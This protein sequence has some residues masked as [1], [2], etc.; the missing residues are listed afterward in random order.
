[1]ARYG[2]GRY[3]QIPALRDYI[4]RIGAEE[5]NFRTFIKRD[6]KGHY[7]TERVTIKI[8]SDGKVTCPDKNMLPSSDEAKE[9]EK[10]I[11]DYQ[12][13]WPKHQRVTRARAR[14]FMKTLAAD[15]V[16]Y[17]YITYDRS[18]EEVIMIQERRI[19]EDG[20][21]YIPWSFWAEDGKAGKWLRMEP[22]GK[23]P[24]WKPLIKD[25]RKDVDKIMVHEGAKAAAHITRL[26]TTKEGDSHPWIDELREYEHWGMQGG[27]L[28][29]QRTDYEELRKRVAEEVVYVCD[30]DFYGKEA[31]K[32]VSEH[33]GGHLKSI[34]FSRIFPKSWDMADP[35]PE[36]LFHRGKYVGKKLATY[37]EP[38]TWATDKHF[39]GEKGRPSVTIKSA[40]AEEWLHCAS[41]EVFFHVNY[42]DQLHVANTFNTII[43]P[44]S[45]VDD[46]A[47][48]LKRA[49]AT[50]G[51]VLKYD[52]SLK[53]G[54]YPGSNNKYFNTHI[55]SDV[56]SVKGD[57]GPWTT[58]MEYLLPD[59]HD[60]TEM[61]RWIA[62][63]VARPEIK[64]TYGVLLI[65]ETQGVGKSTLGEKILAPLVGI[66]NTSFPGEAD[67][68]DPNY[69]YWA[70]HHRLAVVHEIYAG[71]SSK[72]YNKMKSILTDK[73]IM[74]SKKYIDKYAIENWL[75]VF[76]CSNSTRALKLAIEDRRWFVP[77]V[78]EDKQPVRFWT[79]L[80]E[81]LKY[82]GLGIVKHWCEEWIKKNDI[83]LPG[84]DAPD[85]KKK[86]EVISEGYSDGMREVEEVLDRIKHALD[87]KDKSEEQLRRFLVKSQMIH[88]LRSGTI[89]DCPSSMKLEEG[90]QLVAF[91]CDIALV[92]M[93]K[94]NV[95][96]GKQTEY[97]EKPMTIRKVAKKTGKWFINDNLA[98]FRDPS[99]Q[100]KSRLIVSAAELSK[101]AL[102]EFWDEAKGIKFKPVDPRL[103]TKL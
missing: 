21:A 49:Q 79:D 3:L 31:V 62:T 71:N 5:L 82:D 84:A 85:T 88:V 52:P 55:G 68:V 27:A 95:Y 47:R 15:S 77:R 90:D 24:F 63:L 30:N 72:A 57:A 11:L 29:P 89:V 93:I 16:G 61:Y 41:P 28:A 92:E 2:E 39:S 76:A 50:K 46:T 6:Y 100:R 86:E 9:I 101:K 43:R 60:R 91:I 59:E 26:V 45:D 66:H 23:L 12:D 73:N 81:W 48:L 7:Y 75:H 98:T 10:A 37:V 1:M 87:P 102:Q 78:T 99:W 97:L 70:G 44:F 69:N 18:T 20:K 65:S 35:M 51:R 83:V 56:V 25:R 96:H 40:F 17:E 14:E 94:E 53:S 4:D 32:S 42:P 64:M 67:I 36:E 13:K 58:F 103:M 80:N 19:T 74:V 22:E 54:F 33:F 8:G 34:S 38:A